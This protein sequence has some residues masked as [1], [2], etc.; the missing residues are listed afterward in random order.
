MGRQVG[1]E[2]ISRRRGSSSWLYAKSA[3]SKALAELC[4]TNE[5]YTQDVS[6]LI[7]P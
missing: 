2:L 1:L 7:H 5:D 3:G 6:S 4:A